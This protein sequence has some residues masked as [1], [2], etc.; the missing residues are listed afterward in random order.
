V[1]QIKVLLADDQTI[2]R[3]GL[4]ALLEGNPDIMV[5]AEARNGMEAYEQTGIHHPQVVLMDIRMPQMGGV[6]ATRMIK[7]DFPETAVLI[8][9]TYDDDKSIIGAITHGASG[10]LLKDISG[11]KLSEAVR[12]AARGSVILPGNIAAKITKH[13]GM[14][15]RA[16]I[17]LSDF[18]QREQDIIRLL[19]LGKS[20]QEIAQTLFLS[21]GTV[22]NY[23]SQIYG[24]AGITDRA[25]AI[26]YFKELG[27]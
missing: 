24:K 11:A 22:K 14:Q 8:L 4:R 18:T 16:D 27:F 25:N 23:I 3:E 20:N 17:S 10:Y 5:V 26:L 13:I 7:Q 2:I 6:E 9:T 12:D 15:R 21:V 1:N 19:I